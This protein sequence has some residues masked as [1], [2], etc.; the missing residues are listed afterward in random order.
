[1]SAGAAGVAPRPGRVLAILAAAQLLAMTPWFS[2]SAVAPILA[3]VWSLTPSGAAW[4]TISVQ[5]GFV[6]GAM[7]SAVLSLADRWSARRLAAG[8]AALAALATLGVALA[9]G[10]AVGMTLRF[11]TGA[12]LAGVYPP[13]MKL[14]AGWFRESRGVALGVLVGALTLGSAAPHL[15]RWAVPGDAWRLVLMIAA[16][17]AGVGALLTLAVPHDGPYAAP[18]PPFTWSAVPTLLR[19]RA[20]VLANLGY[21]GHM[22]ELYAMWTWLAVFVRASERAR[23][24]AAGD[25]VAVAAV[26][27]FVVIGSGAVGSWLA[28]RFADRLGRTRVTSFALALSGGCALTVG[29]LFGKPLWVLGPLLVLWGVTVVADSAQFSAAVSELAPRQYVGTA[30]TLQTSLGF[31]LTALT[32]YML[33]LAA[34]HVGWRWVMLLLVPGP[35]LGLWA[36]L[37]LRR[38]PEARLLAGGRG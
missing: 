14:A 10:A 24:G 4:L 25:G 7:V 33:P 5:L 31:L 32:I 36:M 29:A 11:V 1:V 26:T 23:V 3:G 6:A 35:L 12:A 37:R 13:G 18:S 9:P 15:V 22:W 21:L 38:R 2:A 28:G 19:D 27:T 20:V 16:G 8:S 34:D 30:L 17:L